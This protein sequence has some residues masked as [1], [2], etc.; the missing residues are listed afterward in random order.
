MNAALIF[1]KALRRAPNER[2]KEVERQLF[3]VAFAGTNCLAA[4]LWHDQLLEAGNAVCSLDGSR[5]I[6]K[7]TCAV[8]FCILRALLDG[9][10]TR[11]YVVISIGAR[12][13]RDSR[14]QWTH[15]QTILG[16]SARVVTDEDLLEAF[17]EQEIDKPVVFVLRAMSVLQLLAVAG[18]KG[19]DLIGKARFIID[20][21]HQRMLTSDTLCAV[22][23]EQIIGKDV[24][25]HV[26]LI[27]AMGDRRVLDIFADVQTFET[28]YS[29]PFE[30][31]HRT[32][33]VSSIK[34]LDA[35]AVNEVE[36]LVKE[37]IAGKLQLGHILLIT[38]THDRINRIMGL[39]EEKAPEWSSDETTCK[40]L[41]KLDRWEQS[42]E[43]FYN[44]LDDRIGGKLENAMYIFPVKFTGT[45]SSM[46]RELVMK[47]I[48][49][50]PNVV[51]IICST[52]YSNK[53]SETICNLAAV[54]DCGIAIKY[55]HCGLNADERSLGIWTRQE[56]PESEQ[57]RI[58]RREKVG[59]TRSGVTVDL[60]ICEKGWESPEFPEPEYW[61]TED[62][63]KIL[64]YR[65]YGVTFEKL[66]KFPAPGMLEGEISRILQELVHI[67]ALDNATH[68]LTQKG[69]AMARLYPIQ[70]SFAAAIIEVANSYGDDS[71]LACI[72]GCLV[73]TIINNNHY[74]QIDT[75]NATIFQRH[76][77]DDSD[78][79][80]LV[81]VFLEVMTRS[82]GNVYESEVGL[83]LGR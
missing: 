78:V 46:Q 36:S 20:D 42:R 19:V 83:L 22:L 30:V 57:S 32:A 50:Y 25:L 29:E 9:L 11:P 33:K 35:S 38:S 4:Y 39:I 76:Y 59:R 65:E 34:E 16:D 70:P 1:A 2:V 77:C 52:G 3:R 10:E 14:R 53:A 27:S 24:P 47:P 63:A 49:G 82:K 7:T 43:M 71:S 56:F 68:E 80:T 58:R 26:W 31:T 74:W 45:C 13:L 55:W 37:M 51:K 17:D 73:A 28:P 23:A 69:M 6:G 75:T 64:R 41:T 48:A 54:I 15:Y 5:S 72:M 79:L 18:R 81:G 62:G 60:K 44:M 67:S 8:F 66:S 21:V 61:Y 12:T 40:V